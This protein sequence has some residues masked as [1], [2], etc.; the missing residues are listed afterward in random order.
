MENWRIIMAVTFRDFFIGLSEQAPVVAQLVHDYTIFQYQQGMAERKFQLEKAD[1]EAGIQ[2]KQDVGK[3]YDTMGEIAVGEFGMKKE[4]QDLLLP[5]KVETARLQEETAKML[6]QDEQEMRKAETLE[7]GGGVDAKREKLRLTYDTMRAALDTERMKLKEAE[8]GLTSNKAITMH[9][10]MAALIESLSYINNIRTGT[11]ELA[12]DKENRDKIEPIIS[13]C[14]DEKTGMYDMIK[15]TEKLREVKTIP[16]WMRVSLV[17]AFEVS[18]QFT[19]FSKQEDEKTLNT[20]RLAA[21]ANNK[22]ALKTLGLKNNKDPFA[23]EAKVKELREGMDKTPDRMRYNNLLDMVSKFM[24]GFN[25]G[26]SGETPDYTGGAGEPTTFVPD[27]RVGEPVETLDEKNKRLMGERAKSMIN[28][29]LYR[30]K[31][32]KPFPEYK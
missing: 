30:F 7:F 23:I 2:Q 5:H 18:N 27:T 12:I 1:V 3:Y 9:H 29:T 26:I 31:E 24:G 4:E 16:E 28:K 11:M 8:S 15:V 20:T 14:V 32:T 10:N 21:L 6:N 19:T 17:N 25:Q 22:D 13:S